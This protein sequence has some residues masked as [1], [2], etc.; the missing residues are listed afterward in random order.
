M[1]LNAN[2]FDVW[3]FQRRPEGVVFLL[4]HTSIEKANRYFNGGRFW[5]I[6]S[7]LLHNDEPIV[8]GVVRALALYGLI[9][10]SIWAGEHAY[11]IYNRRFATMQAIGVYAAEVSNAAVRLEPS[12]HSEY[13]WFS[14]EQ[15]L[16]LVHYRGL[17]DGLRSVHEYV[18]GSPQ[19]AKELCLY[20]VTTQ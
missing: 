11:I 12:E 13:G 5:Q 10:T 8:D 4:L 20:P 16:D 14:L 18:T 6:P 1:R 3:A 19:P 17:K 2:V 15:C 9:A 7:G